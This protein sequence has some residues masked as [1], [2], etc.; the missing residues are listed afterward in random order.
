MV[1]R[2]TMLTIVALRGIMVVEIESPTYPRI[3]KRESS[4]IL[5]FILGIFLKTYLVSDIV[6]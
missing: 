3:H 6:R 2:R 4:L 5:P 1:L